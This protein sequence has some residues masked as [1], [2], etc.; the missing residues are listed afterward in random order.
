MKVLKFAAKNYPKLLKYRLWGIP[1]PFLVT[2]G[3]TNRC[4]LKCSYCFVS[5]E[6]RANKELPTEKLLDY[7]DQFVEIGA[8]DFDLQGGEPTLHPDLGRIISHIVSRGAECTIAT[9]GFMVE[10]HLEDLK[11]CYRV[12]V[13]IDG[14]PQTT[15]AKRGERAYETA[16]K[17]LELMFRAGISVRM[18]GVLTYTTRREDID[19]LVAL[20]KKYNTNVNFVYVLDSG[21]KKNDYEGQERGFVEEIRNIARYLKEVKGKGEPITSKVGAIKQVLNWPFGSQDVLIESQMTK[22]EKALMKK[23]SIPRCLWGHLACFFNPDGRLYS[24]PRAFDREGFYVDIKDRS[25]SEAFSELAKKRP[26]YMCGQMGDLSYSF[27]LSIDNIKT[28][29][30]F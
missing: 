8:L 25:I 6:K 16:I 21:I 30:K 9:N 1:A 19:H 12:C 7:I 23:S 24:C 2:F 26:C 10:R 18:H 4:N 20:A 27:S 11:K 14:L 28:W 15:N 3:I 29:L 17:A 13:S 5:P 22:E